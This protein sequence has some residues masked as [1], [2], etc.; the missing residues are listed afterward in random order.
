MCS[1]VLCPATITNG[2]V[3]EDVCDRRVYSE[4]S[5]SC[6]LGFYLNPEQTKVACTISGSWD[7]HNKTSCLEFDRGLVVMVTPGNGFDHF[8]SVPT[9]QEGTPRLKN[10][11][12]YFLHFDAKFLNV[13]GDYALK[14]AYFY[15]YKTRTIYKDSTFSISLT[16]DNTMT[17]LHIGLSRSYIRLAVDWI[18]HNV[19]WTDS[20]YKWIMVQSPIGNDTSMHRVLIHEN[21]EGPHAL[22]LDPNEALLFWSDIGS[23]T[24]I[25]VSSL[26]GRD[27][28]SL[29][30]SSLNYPY[31]LA[32]DYVDRRLYFTDSIRNTL[33]TMTYEGRDRKVLLN[34]N[35]QILD[36]AIYKEYLYMTAEAG[37]TLYF[38]NK[39]NGETLDTGLSARDKTFY[40]ITVFAPDA[41][42][43]SNKA[44]CSRFGCAQICVTEKDGASCLCKDGYSINQDKK[45]CSSKLY[46]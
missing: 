46:T 37:K 35:Y 19:Y 8:Y 23:V 22:V 15:D 29:I 38:L 14:Q 21:L 17:A 5:F 45:T 7:E 39:T 20:R 28:K 24:K 41:Q 18:S 31:T 11:I 34:H 4:C 12:E 3:D 2:I 9:T 16:G 26:S 32:A 33:E 36:I 43:I 13:D 42:P 30:V 25:E 40:G 1:D 44:N 10:I 27:R 6:D